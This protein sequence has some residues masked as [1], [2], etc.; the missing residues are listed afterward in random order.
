MAGLHLHMSNRLERLADSLSELLSEPL[1]SPFEKEVIVVQS[2]GMERWLRMELA[3]RHGISAN[4]DFPF[5]NAFVKT[6][7]S[8]I[9]SDQPF[10]DGYDKDTMVWRVMEVLPECMGDPE[11]RDIRHYLDRCGS[12][13]SVYQLSKHITACFDQYLV[14]RPEMIMRWEQGQGK[15]WQ[16]ILW[17]KLTQQ[18]EPIH[19]AR[20]KDILL[21][22]IEAGRPLWNCMPQ[23]VS[24]F[25]ISSLPPYHIDIMAAISGFIDVHFFVMNPCKEYWFDIV[26]ERKLDLII[27]EGGADYELP[28]KLHL[29]IGNALLASMGHL[30]RDFLS[31][32]MELDPEEHTYFEA[33]GAE[34]ILK[35]IQSDIL[36]LKEPTSE[37]GGPVV[38]KDDD[39]SISVHSCHSPLREMEVLYDRLLDIFNQNPDIGPKDVVVMAPDIRQ[40]APFIDAVFGRSPGDPKAIPYSIADRGYLI[41]GELAPAL[42]DLFDFVNSRFTVSSVLSFLEREPVKRRF[43]LSDKDVMTIRKW[44][45]DTRIHWGIDEAMKEDMG[46][47]PTKQN[48]W[49]A[50]IERLLLGFAFPGQGKTL[51]K[52]IL[53][54]DHVEGEDALLLGKLA[55]LLRSI[56]Q[57]ASLFSVPASVEVW[58]ERLTNVIEQ[59]FY[60]GETSQHEFQALLEIIADLRSAAGKARSNAKVSF[61]V[62]RAYLEARFDEAG[63]AGGFLNKGVTFCSILPMRSIPFKVVCLIGMNHDA[64]PRHS[65]ELAFDLM[66]ARP[67]KGDRSR[68][69]DDRYLFLEAILSARQYLI[70]TY[71]GQSETD[72]STIPPS[73]LVSE[74]LDYIERNFIWEGGEVKDRILTKHRLRAF[75]SSYFD[76]ESTLFTYFDEKLEPARLCVK[77]KEELR[78]FFKDE[79]SIL[80]DDVK[81]IS[82]ENLEDFLSNP[83]KFILQ[84]RLKI[85]LKFDSPLPPDQEPAVLKGLE[86]YNVDQRLLKAKLS[87]MSLESVYPILKAEGLLPHG[88]VGAVEYERRSMDID[89]FSHLIGGLMGDGSPQWVE[90][91]TNVNGHRLWGRIGEI[92]ERGLI[93][94]R[95]ADLRARD[96]LRLWLY[97]L[98]INVIAEGAMP[99]RSFLCGRDSQWM[100]RPVENAQ[101]YLGRLIELYI[102]G[103][104]RPAKFFPESSFVYASKL[105]RG[106]QSGAQALQSAKRVWEG[107]RY[108]RGE[109][110]DDYFR[111]C[112]GEQDPLDGG[113]AEVSIE[114]FSPLLAHREKI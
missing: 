65:R 1:S 39:S 89:E 42:F 31:F 75:N 47:P 79:L 93:H 62:V 45:N 20:A 88:S 113:F 90:V 26:T 50:G 48:T 82:I 108:N 55:S 69:N 2:R 16:A 11:F 36:N 14:F 33:P 13:E 104:K 53:P 68:R 66:A 10:D 97:H 58:Y 4:L 21:K 98:V 91:D 64:Y 56:T 72:N 3:L 17:R 59:L 78:K 102:E 19:K 5:P 6:I 101:E 61:R 70:V 54:Y 9:I 8:Q 87:G 57:A 38:I 109:K 96:H 29:E 110:E 94:Y 37:L 86:A 28:H 80:P 41:S 23:R 63:L 25:G 35:T 99:V 92:Y 105:K 7:Y 51:F 71:V 60:P 107:S 76:P 67:R 111:L 95:F 49:Q 103:L 81:E 32:L 12:D 34:T 84:K 27:K 100:Y 44:V 52:E 40:Y 22:A 15:H 18:G 112:F 73:A 106:R 46:L 77:P 114:V 83:A 74:L 24:I 30:G 43:G 85:R